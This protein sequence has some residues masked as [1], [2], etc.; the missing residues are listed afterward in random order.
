MVTKHEEHRRHA[1]FTITELARR[2][3]VS[4]PYASKIE[5]GKIP[6]SKRYREAFSALCHVPEEWVFDS[7]GRVLQ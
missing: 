1:G 4:R 7:A 2:A 6:A 3:K 5:A